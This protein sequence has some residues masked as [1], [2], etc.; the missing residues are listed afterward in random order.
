MINKFFMRK[1]AQ[2]L[3]IQVVYSDEYG[4]PSRF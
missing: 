1:N 4:F 3:I 2:F